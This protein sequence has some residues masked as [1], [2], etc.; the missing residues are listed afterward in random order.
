MKTYSFIGS[1]KNAGKTTAFNYVYR[2]LCKKGGSSIC[3]SSI[4]INGEEVDNFEGV[5]KP[6][7]EILPGL[8][9]I[10]K[11]SRLTGHTG[12][13]RTLQTF[14][15][16]LFNEDYIL[17]KA[18][19]K[20]D[21]ILEGPNSGDEIRIVKRSISPLL[22]NDGL[23]LIDGSI[24]RQFLAKPEIS[25]GFYFSLLFTKRV[26]QRQKTLDFLE[27]LAL[28]PCTKEIRTKITGNLNERTK[29][30]LIADSGKIIHQGQSIVSRD[31]ELRS[32]CATMKQC[33]E[34]VFFLYLKGALTNSLY[35]FLAPFRGLQVIL[36]NFS[37]FQN[38]STS[39]KKKINFL[40]KISLYN[41]RE[42]KTIFI[43]QETDFD[44]SLLPKGIAVK[45]LFRETHY[46]S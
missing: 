39:E 38:I 2:D 21:L 15:S 27:M 28:V 33:D 30:L 14:T 41:P 32:K 12:K 8:F 3:L 4:G 19:L 25:D 20:M 43:S 11:A 18:Q 36:D 22:G 17:G 26:E 10:T 45:N 1:D 16:P 7:I 34:I 35:N 6:Q 31:K 9:F 13:Y 5:K 46:E 23:L 29:S 40:P 44:H 24:D 37:L 42:I